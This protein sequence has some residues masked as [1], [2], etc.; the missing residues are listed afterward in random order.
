MNVVKQFFVYQVRQSACRYAASHAQHTGR[1]R[2]SH[3]QAVGGGLDGFE[4]VFIHELCEQG[5][6]NRLVGKVQLQ[7]AQAAPVEKPGIGR[8]QT[9]SGL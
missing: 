3:Q 2:H 8:I 1:T 9:L 6:V 5:G 4:M 7:A